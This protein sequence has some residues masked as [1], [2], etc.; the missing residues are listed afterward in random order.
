MSEIL[1]RDIGQHADYLFSLAQLELRL[2]L[3]KLL[4]TYDFRLVDDELDWVADNK[5]YV[6]WDKPELRVHFTRRAT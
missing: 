1:C 3:C 5:S 6:F 4:W 2:T